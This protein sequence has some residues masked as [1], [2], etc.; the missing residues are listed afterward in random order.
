[1]TKLTQLDCIW[2]NNRHNAFTDLIEFN[3]RFYCCFREATN[4]ISPDGIIRILVSD[5]LKRWQLISSVRHISADLRDPKLIKH[6]SGKMLLSFYRKRFDKNGQNIANENC[7]SFSLTGYSWSSAKIIGHNNWWMWRIRNDLGIAYNRKQNTV[8]LYQG[9]PLRA[10]HLVNDALFSLKNNA[11]GYPNESDVLKLPDGRTICI[12]RRDA[13]SFSAQLGISN[14]SNHNWKW[15]DLGL[16]LGG[17]CMLQLENG[18]ILVAA[19]RFQRPRC[20]TTWLF[21]LDI[22]TKSIKPVLQLPSAGDNSY[23]AMLAH[24]NKLHVSYYSQHQENRYSYASAIYLAE[25]TL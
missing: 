21:E 23:P 11:K 3:G 24:D 5:D 22:N 1:M 2:R 8:R 15:Y 13:D 10:F 25:V 16:Y 17:P 12:L 7:I 9:D 4:H 18:R 19:R 14:I 20:L 6:H